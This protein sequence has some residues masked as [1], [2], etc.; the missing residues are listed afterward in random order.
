LFDLLVLVLLFKNGFVYFASLTVWL[1][2]LILLTVP[3]F[4][5]RSLVSA[6]RQ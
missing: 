2:Y 5:G 1:A 4:T 6:E 3:W